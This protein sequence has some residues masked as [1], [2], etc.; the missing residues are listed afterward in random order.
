MFSGIMV[1]V[2][3]GATKGH[4]WG[5]WRDGGLVQ[6][7]FT[8]RVPNYGGSAHLVIEQMQT[9]GGRAGKGDA[10][11]LIAVAFAAGV[12]AADF[13]TYEQVPARVWKGS[14]PKQI[15]LKRIL[16]KLSDTE[17]AAV[18][19][20]GLNKKAEENVIDAIGIGLFKLGRL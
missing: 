12:V 10:N 5:F 9:Y 6:C 2:D 7:G 14:V 3:P 17:L 11:D 15:M 1:S 20:L 8:H 18:R 13:C 16:S 4:G 19:G